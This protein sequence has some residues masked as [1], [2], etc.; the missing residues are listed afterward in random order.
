MT[1]KLIE[2]T[3]P[4]REISELA[5]P[6][7][8]SYK[9]IYQISKWFARRASSTFRA[10]LL[11]SILPSSADLMKNFY[12]EHNFSDFTVI[13]PFM[14]GGTTIIE[15]LRLGLNCIGVDINPVAWFITKTE[16][17]LVD[18]GELEKWIMDCEDKIKA[19]IKKWYLTGQVVC[20]KKNLQPSYVQANLLF[21]P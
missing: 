17:E 16:A 13:D 5:I 21:T 1:S 2:E 4:I 8:S 18:L 20:F 10:I 19:Q 12:N 9:P 3:F 15:G 14:G 7:R 6:E 11:G